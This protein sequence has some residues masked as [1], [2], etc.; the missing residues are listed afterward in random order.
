[1][2][3]TPS[4]GAPRG[5]LPSGERWRDESGTPHSPA[6]SSSPRTTRASS[7]NARAARALRHRG[8]V[9]RRP[10]P[11]RA[12]RDRHDVSRQRAHQGAGRRAATSLPAFA[13]DSGLA[14]DALGGAPGIHSARWAGAAK[15]FQLRHAARRGRIGARAPPRRP[16]PRAFRLGA[17][18]RLA[19]RPYGGLRGHGRRHAGLAAARH[20]RLRLRSDVPAGRARRAPSAR[21]RRRRSTA[22]RR[23]AKASRTAPAPFSSSP[24]RACRTPIALVTAGR[25]GAICWCMTA[26]SVRRLRPLAVL[27]VEVPVLR[28]QQPRA[29]RGDRRGA[30]RARVRGRDRRHGGANGRPHGLDHLLRRRHA[31]ADAARDRGGDPRRHRAALDG[32]ARRRSVA[33]GESDERR[34]DALPRLSRGR[35]QPGV[36]R[37]AGARRRGAEGT[38]TAA[39]RA[40]GARCGRGARGRTSSATR[41][42]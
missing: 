40:R 30:V 3:G 35:R 7:G 42:T 31:L 34:G 23:A 36:A 39:Q 10:R 18:R 20:A 33:R 22:C 26:P 27:P 9:G 11:R 28:L 12:G 25:R 29:P 4:P 21:C 32:R 13:D 38:R 14:V 41:S 5:P 6:G 16:P 1:M 17:V 2:H 37:R 24:P 8:G 19:G 15:D